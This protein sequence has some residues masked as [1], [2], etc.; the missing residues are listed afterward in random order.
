MKLA[1]DAYY[2]NI[3]EAK[4]VGLIF[5]DWNA[6]EPNKIVTT[7]VKDVQKYEPGKF[8]K[9]ELPCIMKLLELINMEVVEVIIIDGYVY[10]DDI[11]KPGLGFHLYEKLN[12]KYP[13]IGVAKTYYYNNIALKICR[14]QSKTPL[15]I[16][17]IGININDAG[18]NIKNMYGEYR[19]PKLLKL[20]DKETK[21]K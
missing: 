5:E 13:I 9:R 8:Y 4:V 19:M 17:S 2:N 18:N 21:E 3:N 6:I 14:G 15:Y 7:S 11:N 10:L 1:I 20:L 12:K 16:T